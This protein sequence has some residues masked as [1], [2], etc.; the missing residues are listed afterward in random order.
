MEKASHSEDPIVFFD[1]VCHLCNSF[2][3]AVISRDPQ[4]RLKFAPL[5]GETAARLLAPEVRLNLNTVI[6]FEAGQAYERSNAILK[7]FE[8]LGGLYKGVRI[9]RIFP[10]GLRDIAYDFVA[11]RRYGWFGEKD[12]CRIPLPS[13]RDYLL[14]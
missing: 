4:H 5:Q 8:R 12:L 9:L 1:G 10:R 11:R 2:V 13:E 14:P 6:Y 7:I 3:D